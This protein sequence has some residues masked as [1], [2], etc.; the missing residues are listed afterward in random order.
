MKIAIIANGPNALNHE[1]GDFIDSCD[2]VVRMNCYQISGFEKFIGTKTD[3]W[4]TTN[5]FYRFINEYDGL[6][7]ERQKDFFEENWTMD[8]PR[9]AFFVEEHNVPCGEI[10]LLNLW[11]G[12]KDNR[13]FG[14]VFKNN[15][16]H[17]NE[18]ICLE[19]FD[20]GI[21]SGLCKEYKVVVN[22]DLKRIKIGGRKNLSTGLHTLVYSIVRWIGEE[23]YIYGFD[24]FEKEEEYFSTPENI[25]VDAHDGSAEKEIVRRW[26]KEGILRQME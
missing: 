21:I 4:V 20:G 23:I 24:F 2:V 6:L 9:T 10:H 18:N 17:F 1:N 22:N 3:I 12:N 8:N 15:E 16:L 5:D 14:S 19:T 13:I 7:E 25:W 26:L 11:I